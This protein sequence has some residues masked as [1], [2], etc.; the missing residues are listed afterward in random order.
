MANTARRR[1]AP[2]RVVNQPQRSG[3][4]PAPE[5]PRSRFKRIAPDRLGKVTKAIDHLMQLANTTVYDVRPS[6]KQQLV[7]VIKEKADELAFVLD[8]PGKAPPILQFEDEE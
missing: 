4:A 1:A 8:H 7:A 3:P 2:L 5:S 6:E